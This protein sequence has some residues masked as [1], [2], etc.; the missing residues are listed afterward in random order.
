MR[1]TTYNKWKTEEARR[2]LEVFIQY[3]AAND[4]KAK[5]KKKNKKEKES[6]KKK[7]NRPNFTWVNAKQRLKD[8][9]QGQIDFRRCP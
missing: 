6:K 2:H 1:C 8:S 3:V 4:D 7:V 9:S 5:Q